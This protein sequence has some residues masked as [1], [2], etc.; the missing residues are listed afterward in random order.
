MKK[1]TGSTNLLVS[2]ALQL[3]VPL[4]AWAQAPAAV[5]PANP[6]APVAEQV[7]APTAA[8]EAAP[9]PAAAPAPEPAPQAAPA[10]VQPAASGDTKASVTMGNGAV[11]AT[12]GAA[13]HGDDRTDDD[14]SDKALDENLSPWQKKPKI[15]VGGLIHSAYV[16]TDAEGQPAHEF[17]IRTAR[18]D[19]NWRQG[20][21]LEGAVE[22]DASDGA[23]EDPGMWGPLRDAYAEVKPLDEL[24]LRMGQF[25]KPFGRLALTSQRKLILV[26]RG[27]SHQW[28]VRD[29]GYGGRDIGLEVHGDLLDAPRIEY[30]VGAFNGTGLNQD[31]EDLDG[32]KDFAGRVQIDPLPWLSVGVDGSYKRFDLDV[33]SELPSKS[34]SVFGLDLAVALDRFNFVGEAM[35]GRNNLALSLAKSWSVLGMVSYEIPLAPTWELALL[36]L[37]KGE[38]LKIEHDVRESHVL[39]GT[40]GA[41]L[42]VGPFFRLMVQGEMQSRTENVPDDWQDEKRLFVQAALQTR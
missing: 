36:P 22:L 15:R 2:L 29:L 18:M 16:T 9:A 13:A 14:S 31:E 25:K 6:P 28:M 11:D 39:A 21:L 24:K 10:P 30:A 5:A 1:H 4:T 42:H 17:K 32:S 27:V 40:L 33:R 7:A 20:K 41:N 8:P 26:D 34:A 38:M 35:L 3:G 12:A 37:V 23:S 19:L